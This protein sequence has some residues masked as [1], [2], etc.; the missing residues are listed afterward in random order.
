MPRAVRRLLPAVALVSGCVFGAQL[1]PEEIRARGTRH[2]D[3]PPDKVFTAAISALQSQGYEIAVA[4]PDKGILR[5]ARKLV[6]AAATGGAGYAQA[7]AITRQ[8]HLTVKADGEGTKVVARP[9]VFQ[10]DADLSDGSVWQLDC[11]AGERTLW[12]RLFR[13]IQELL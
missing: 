13:E 12:D 10:G 11:A 3:A 8:Y 1:T 4:E 6:R 9:K 5:T 2:F 7:V